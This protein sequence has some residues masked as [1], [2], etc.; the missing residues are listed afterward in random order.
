MQAVGQANTHRFNHICCQ[1]LINIG[2]ALR[3]IEFIANFFEAHLI[4]VAQ[5]HN[6]N[7]LAQSL[8][9]GQMGAANAGANNTY[10]DG[11]M[12]HRTSWDG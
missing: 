3:H 12:T 11:G 9:A 10:L 7:L 8:I 6:V 4:R 1:Q 2:I 5:G